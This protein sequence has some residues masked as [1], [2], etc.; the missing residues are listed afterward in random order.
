MRGPCGRKGMRRP[1]PDA[2]P[3][4]AAATL[5]L[6]LLYFVTF[7]SK[8]PLPAPT[9]PRALKGPRA[10]PGEGVEGA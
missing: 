5:L 2:P 6:L 8:I 4:P 3:L 1:L 9:M 7:R 10:P